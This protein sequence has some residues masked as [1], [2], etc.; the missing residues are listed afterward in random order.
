MSVTGGLGHQGG[1][2]HLDAVPA[3]D[4]TVLSEQDV[5]QGAPATAGP[6]ETTA[7]FPVTVA[8]DPHS[9]SAPGPQPTAASWA[10]QLAGHQ[11]ALDFGRVGSYD[12]HVC[13]RAP[14][15]ALPS[16]GQR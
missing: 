13:L 12:L 14:G 8:H 5:G 7:L 4:Q 11:G 9:G 6:P 3:P 16:L 2:D 15:R 10:S 1:A